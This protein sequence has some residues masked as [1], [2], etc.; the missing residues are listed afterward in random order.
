MIKQ[1][2]NKASYVLPA[3]VLGVVWVLA[4]SEDVGRYDAYQAVECRRLVVNLTI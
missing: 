1:I 4:T 2:L 3:F